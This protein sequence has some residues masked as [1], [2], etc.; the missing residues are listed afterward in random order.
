MTLGGS[1]CV[2]F[3]LEININCYF[4]VLLADRWI[5][6]YESDICS[7]T[8]GRSEG[9]CHRQH[10]SPNFFSNIYYNI[11]TMPKIAP[12]IFAIRIGVT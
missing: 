9:T 6:L 1:V 4:T 10:S 8:D 3:K 12:K 11:F 2:E 5:L 7:V